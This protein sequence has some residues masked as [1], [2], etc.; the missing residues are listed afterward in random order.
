MGPER[1]VVLGHPPPQRDPFERHPRDRGKSGTGRF[2]GPVRGTAG[3]RAHE[4]S[5]RLARRP[6]IRATGRAPGLGAVGRRAFRGAGRPARRHG[7]TSGP[8]RVRTS[9]LEGLTRPALGFMWAE[10]VRQVHF[11]E[12]GG[13]RSSPSLQQFRPGIRK[14]ARGRRKHPRN[15]GGHRNYSAEL[16]VRYRK[17][18]TA[19]DVV[20]SGFF[21]SIGLYRKASGP[22]GGDRAWME[23]F[24]LQALA[25]KKIQSPLPWRAAHG[26][27]G[28]LD[29]QSSRVFWC[30]TNPAKAWIPT[31]EGSSYRPSTE[32]PPGD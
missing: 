5:L 7:E 24:G 28:A 1:A 11:I 17:D 32:S 2:P 14:T 27:A 29:G 15:Q 31:I 12:P 4:R 22:A 3:G 21:D 10:R 25:G 20:M 6:R 13:G 9:F 19:A 18:V 26:A 8:C 30:W 23:S 16:Q